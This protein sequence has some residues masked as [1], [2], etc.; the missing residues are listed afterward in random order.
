MKFLNPEQFAK[1]AGLELFS[2]K[3]VDGFLS[4]YHQSSFHGYNVEFADH[5]TYERGDDLRN[6]DWKLFG[7]TDR[8]FVKR[9]HEETNLRSFVLLDNSASMAFGDSISKWD[10]SRVLCASLSFL[11]LRQKDSVGV[12]L[13]NEGLQAMVPPRAKKSHFTSICRFLENSSPGGKTFFGES[14]VG[15]A[16]N[17]KKRSLICVISDFL[18]EEDQ[19]FPA[20]RSL[21]GR[22]HDIIVF[23]LL[24]GE[25]Y[26][27]PYRGFYR[28]RDMETG[29]HLD[30]RLDA[31]R[32]EYQSAVNAGRRKVMDFCL[33]AGMDYVQHTTRTP[34]EKVL[35]EYLIKRRRGGRGV[36]LL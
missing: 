6:I 35:F 21:S 31:M 30:L 27:L 9:F 12:W 16:R 20:L 18:G 36:V 26:E 11:M 25:E 4:G 17:L 1:I 10:Y 15:L 8:L 19:I 34:V 29:D 23:H 14:I 22:K 7:R 3:I 24:S 32:S 28:V 5:K 2:R 33:S 13:F